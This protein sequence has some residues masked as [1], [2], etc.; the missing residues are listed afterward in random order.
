VVDPAAIESSSPRGL[1]DL[2]VAMTRATQR[3]VLVTFN[4]VGKFLSIDTLT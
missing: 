4:D 1:N 2:Y 3:L